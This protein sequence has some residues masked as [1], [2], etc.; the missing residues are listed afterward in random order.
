MIKLNK[1]NSFLPKIRW[2]ALSNQNTLLLLKSGTFHKINKFAEPVKQ[3]TIIINVL[4]Q[5]SLNEILR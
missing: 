3:R 2:R 1:E 4:Q 5:K